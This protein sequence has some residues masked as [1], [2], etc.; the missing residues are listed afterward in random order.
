M[1]NDVVELLNQL[2]IEEER[3]TEKNLKQLDEHNELSKKKLYLKSTFRKIDNLKYKN[4][5]NKFV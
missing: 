4:Y 3:G 2:M 5:A 1:G